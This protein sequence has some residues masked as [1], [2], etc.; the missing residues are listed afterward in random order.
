MKKIKLILCD[1]DS[2]TAGD[3]INP[4]LKTSW[5]NDPVNDSYRLPKVGHHQKEKIFI[6]EIPKINFIVIGKHYTQIN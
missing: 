2:W 4:E 6:I 1:G 3:M 5:V